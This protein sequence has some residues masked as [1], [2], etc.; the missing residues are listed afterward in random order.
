[1]PSKQR[2]AGSNPAGR[3]VRPGKAQASKIILRLSIADWCA[4]PTDRRRGTLLPARHTA[5]L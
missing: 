3:Q 1:V 4:R 5:R 2:V